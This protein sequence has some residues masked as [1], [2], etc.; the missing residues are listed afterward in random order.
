MH[1][2]LRTKMATLEK[3]KQKVI[4]DLLLN[5]NTIRF[6][7]LFVVKCTIQGYCGL[8]CVENV[9]ESAHLIEFQML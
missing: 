7:Q 6:V 1:Q 3:P 4:T 5:E 2:I 9:I 8:H